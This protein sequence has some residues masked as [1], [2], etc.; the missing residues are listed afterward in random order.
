MYRFES[1]MYGLQLFWAKSLEN[2]RAMVPLSSPD[3][4]T[5]DDNEHIT[6]SLDLAS[7]VSY[8][9]TF[10]L[11]NKL[12]DDRLFGWHPCRIMGAYNEFL[13]NPLWNF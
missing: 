10:L 13:V 2:L 1:K 4:I 11:V 12:Y 5:S 9:F 3:R 6:H 8:R 7:R